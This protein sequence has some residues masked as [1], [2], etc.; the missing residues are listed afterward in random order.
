MRHNGTT[1][2][3]STPGPE[4]VER[5]CQPE[6]RRQAR[7][8]A[9]GLR[10]RNV[11]SI[12]ALLTYFSLWVLLD[13][14]RWLSEWTGRVSTDLWV[15]VALA[16]LLVG[17]GAWV[18]DTLMAASSHRWARRFGQSTQGWEAWLTD[19]MKAGILAGV[20][21]LIATEGIFLLVRTGRPDW[22]LWA[23]LAIVGLQALLTFIAPTLIA[24]LFFRFD[25]LE[26]PVLRERF[27]RLAKEAGVPAVDVYRFDMSRRTRAANAAVVGIGRT[28]RIIVA[29]TLLSSF[30]PDEAEVILAHELA[31]H[32]H[33]DMQWSLVANGVIMLGGFRLL[34]ALWPWAAQQWGIAPDDPGML[35]VLALFFDVYSLLIA[36]ILNLWSRGREMLAD[37]FA[38]AITGKGR[39][40]A[41]ALA[42]LADQ[43][44]AELWPPRWYVL[45]LGSHP[46]L[47]ERIEMA[48]ALDRETS[49][50]VPGGKDERVA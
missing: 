19:R 7:V 16:F 22:W 21:G 17:G 9:R 23:A 42:R 27:L 46:P 29:D 32:A 20:L 24:P 43:N 25:R 12:F 14:P 35:P 33:R 30:S 39:T 13:G 15:R 3:L 18:V 5:L 28:R 49:S 40:Y 37:I 11:L 41:Q 48:L 36:P 10:R 8:Y 50:V 6:R 45:W 1:P 47:G 2:L 26:D 38:V 31:H 44:L 34:A 4:A